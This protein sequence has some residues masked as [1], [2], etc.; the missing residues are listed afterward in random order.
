MVLRLGVFAGC[1]GLL[2]LLGLRS[3]D[4]QLLLVLLAG[5]LSMVISLFA[6][7]GPR[8]ALSQRIDA[9]VR[10]AAA[11]GET[12]SQDETAEDGEAAQSLDPRTANPESET[13]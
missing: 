12:P 4:Q 9:R 13:R 2:W 8:E 7:K 10:R 3:V 11:R 1:L 5:L 6:L